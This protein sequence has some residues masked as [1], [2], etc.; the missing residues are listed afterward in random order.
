MTQTQETKILHIPF[1][2]TTGVSAKAADHLLE[3]SGVEWNRIGCVDW[4]QDYPYAPTAGFRLAH[5]EDALLVEYRV[6]ERDTQAVATADNGRVWEDSCVEMFLSP[7]PDSDIYYNLETNCLGTVLLANR[8]GG[9]EV[10]HAPMEVLQTIERY[11]SLAEDAAVGNPQTKQGQSPSSERAPLPR[12]EGE[13]TWT[14]T[15]KVPY[16]AFWKDQEQ[17][18]PQGEMRA[19]FYKCGDKMAKPHFLSWSPILAPKPNFHLPQFFGRIIFDS[20]NNY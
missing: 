12:M 9:R 10:E 2:S 18:P 20:Q 5:G 16:S 14:L 4:P 1:V 6:T 11:S 8:G 15:L 3:Q 19:N 7:C 13:H 17:F